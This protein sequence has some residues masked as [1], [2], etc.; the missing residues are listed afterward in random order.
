[1]SWNNIRVEKPYW[2]H[3]LGPRDW[4]PAIKKGLDYLLQLRALVPKKRLVT[5]KFLHRSGWNQVIDMIESGFGFVIRIGKE[6]HLTYVSPTGHVHMTPAV[7][8]ELFEYD[9]EHRLIP[10]RIRAFIEA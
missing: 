2:L 5:A 1:M 3:T 7:R 8:A 9:P 6:Y 10:A 4:S